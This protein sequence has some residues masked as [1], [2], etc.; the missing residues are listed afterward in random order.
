MV[1]GEAPLRLIAIALLAGGH[2]LIEDVPGT[3][4]TLLARAIAD[5]SG[6]TNRIQGSTR[7]PARGR[8]GFQPVRGR[9]PALRARAG[10]HECPSDRR[11]QSSDHV[12]YVDSAG[13]GS[14]VGAYV[15]RNNGGRSLALVGVNDRV[16]TV[17]QVTRVDQFFRFF[18]TVDEVERAA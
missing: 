14:L 5:H 9:E 1:G 8:D 4:K 12:P 11:D 18:N 3:G 13:I 6:S 17:L 16:R 7:P 10:L 15:T 2:V